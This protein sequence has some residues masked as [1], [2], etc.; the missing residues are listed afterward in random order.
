MLKTALCIPPFR[1]K[2][3]SLFN[4]QPKTIFFSQS[5]NAQERQKTTFMFFQKIVFENT[6]FK[7][8]H[9]PI[10]H[11][12]IFTILRMRETIIIDSK[13]QSKLEKQVDSAITRTVVIF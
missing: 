6:I 3:I 2:K 10:R 11:S 13:S 8:L 5:F 4:T 12:Y 7:K 9:Q 1:H